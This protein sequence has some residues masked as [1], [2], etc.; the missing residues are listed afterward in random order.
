MSYTVS[1]I[2]VED[3]SFRAAMV[4]L[5]GI[6]LQLEGNSLELEESLLAYERGVSLLRALQ[7]KLAMAQQTIDVLMGELVPAA[8]DATQDATLS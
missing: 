2:P 3:L 1:A 4:E 8:D 6:L 5:D 7:A